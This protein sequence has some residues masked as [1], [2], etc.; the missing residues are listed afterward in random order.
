MRALQRRA[1]NPKNFSIKPGGAEFWALLSSII[2]DTSWDFMGKIKR[3]GYI[4]W[5][6]IGDH[7]PPHVHVWRDGGFV[8]K[9]DLSKPGPIEGYASR[10]VRA[11]IEELVAEGAFGYENKADKN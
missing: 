6:W 1:T 5:T 9:W 3:G 4:F 10:Q 7:D 2:F 8:V 11:Y